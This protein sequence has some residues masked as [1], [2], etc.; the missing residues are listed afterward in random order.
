[1]NAEQIRILV[2]D[3]DADVARGTLHLL[4]KA[5][6]RT[7]TAANGVLALDLLATFQPQLVLADRNM[8]A[9]DGLELCRH[10]KADPA[11]ADVLVVIIS[12]YYTQ[13]DEQAEG[14]EAGA[15]G[16]ICRPIANR[17]LLAR[18]EAFGRIIGLTSALR[19]SERQF[20]MLADSLPQFVWVARPDGS[21]IYFNQQW[22]DYTGLTLTQSCGH[23]WST[24]FHPDDRQRAQDAWQQAT[25]SGSPYE[26]EGRLRRADGVYRWWLIRGV[27]RRDAEGEIIKWFGT[28]T[29]I[30]D[31]K[32]AEAA[33]TETKALLQAALDQSS[34]GIAIAEAP[35]GKLRYVNRAGLRIR[36]GTTA[37]SMTGVDA[38]R[39]VASW[40]LL[41]LDGTAMARD[42]VPL[43]R[44][45]LFGEECSREFIIQ[46]SPTEQR[47]VLANA[48]PILDS[49]GQVTAGIVVFHD[50]T[51][52]KAVEDALRASENRHRSVLAALT[53]GIVVQAADG[54]NIDCNQSAEKLLG[55]S[56]EQILSRS[57]LDPRWQAVDADGCPLPG[58]QHPGM[59]SLRTGQPCHGVTIGLRLAGGTQR[60]VSINAEPM[61]HSGA[62]I[63]YAVV[64]SFSDV[65]GRRQAVEALRLTSERLT[66]AA[67]AGSVGIWEYDVID[68]RL[69][70]DEQMFRLHGVP[71]DPLSRAY[72]VI[73]AGVHPD[74]RRQREAEVQAAL[75]GETDYDTEFRVVWPDG[76]I[77]N[78]RAIASVQRDAS[79]QALRMVGT[80]W[81]IT[82]S[83]RS[84]AELLETNRRLAAATAAATDLAAK[85]EKANLAKS[86]FLA[87]MSH[88]IR[89]P[90]NG[91]IGMT[92]LLLAGPLSDEQREY[93]RM[94]HCSGEALLKLTNDILDLSKIEAGRLDLESLDFSLPALLHELGELLRIRARDKGLQ[95]SCTST[96]GT[97]EMVCGDSN[98]LRQVLLNLA[99]NAIKFTPRGEVVVQASLVSASATNRVVRF[100]V[101]D[102]GIGIPVDKQALLFRKFSQVDPSTTRHYGGSGLGLAISKQLV[103]LMGGEIGV[104]SVVGHGAEFWFT[105]C[106]VTA[107]RSIPA[108]PQA[109]DPPLAAVAP[110]HHHWPALRVLLAEDNLI[111]QKVAA[112]FLRNMGLPADVVPDGVEAVA[113]VARTAYDLVL[114]DVQMPGMDG[115]DATR[116]IRAAHSR[117]RQPRLPI[118]AMTANAMQMDRE[119]CLEAGMDDHLPKP[120]TPKSLARMLER[121][122]PAPARG[123]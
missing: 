22:L 18:V 81:D 90:M 4:Q 1:M 34:A 87:N 32:A 75:R 123:D 29:V 7:A 5:G 64:S 20:V 109:P 39:Y 36:G 15:D 119:K 48:A 8:P 92:S 122:L 16:Y 35:S 43:A 13:S 95:F 10:I 21:G 117:T 80:N 33:L 61:F 97:P 9:M 62:T 58:E 11:W 67:R 24:P 12:G 46:R 85:A 89:T 52:R 14:L 44:A 47:I 63:P 111:N 45:V 102:T 72:D 96:P 107:A 60:W 83:R 37:E 74:D 6:Y 17:E 53:E 105:A 93:A 42:E 57:S 25:Q 78:I 112:G 73:Q 30:D 50:I 55:L 56:R 115:L 2:V 118:I 113:A 121:W 99:G 70:W 51:E 110:M 108:A 41:H 3:D 101:R 94:A 26:L 104:S 54:S 84:K 79:G 82:A 76:S 100:V 71:P 91:I 116:T 77:H 38:E 88:E 120:I 69:M 86:E 98:R 59:V 103:D 49:A 27:P 106:F 31:L 28:C 19:T 66:L 68:K 65:T 40:K 114:M 23:G